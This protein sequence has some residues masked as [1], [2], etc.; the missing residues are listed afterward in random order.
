MLTLQLKK[1]AV[2][3]FWILSDALLHFG[4]AAPVL[5]SFLVNPAPSITLGAFLQAS[6]VMEPNREKRG[7]VG[8]H[9]KNGGDIP[10]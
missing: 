2:L 8:R 6:Y 10:R 1:I 5:I 3:L 4:K 9:V 7:E